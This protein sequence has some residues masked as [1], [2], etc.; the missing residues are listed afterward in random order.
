MSRLRSWSPRRSSATSIRF[1][2][3]SG[4][5]CPFLSLVHG[6]PMQGPDS[7]PG[8]RVQEECSR[9]GRKE[10]G[11]HLD[12]GRKK[13]ASVSGADQQTAQWAGRR[14]DYEAEVAQKE[15]VCE[16]RV[17]PPSPTCAPQRVVQQA[18]HEGKGSRGL[19]N[20]AGPISAAP[21]QPAPESGRIPVMV[22]RWQARAI[23]TQRR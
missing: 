3:A 23:H 6:L 21:L 19:T 9:G 1:K 8:P 14:P 20:T 12:R 11:S 22:S 13:A 4:E 7:H 10:H 5:P 18:G 15:D 16:G 17:C 2:L